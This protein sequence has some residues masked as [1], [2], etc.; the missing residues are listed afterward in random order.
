MD[1]KLLL[2]ALAGLLFFAAA[3]AACSSSSKPTYCDERQATETSYSALTDTNVVTEGTNTL[4]TRFDTFTNDLKDLKSAAG[5]EFS[6]EIDAVQSAA[7]DVGTVVDNADTASLS[8]T[9]NQLSSSLTGL[10]NSVKGL[11]TEMDNAC[12]GTK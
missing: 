8:T 1:R 3:G 9:A 5:T 11:F 10:K 2:I 12:N 6:S 4:K 7:G